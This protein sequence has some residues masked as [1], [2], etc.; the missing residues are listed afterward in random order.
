MHFNWKKMTNLLKT[1]VFGAF[2]LVDIASLHAAGAAQS[3]LLQATIELEKPVASAKDTEA[4]KII[5]GTSI[6]LKA[7]VVNNGKV[8][9]APG[10]VF[11][12]FALPPPLD[13][14]KNSVMFQTE[15][16]TLPSIPPGQTET[17]TFTSGHTWPTLYDFIRDD[18]SLRQYQAVV[19]IKDKEAVIGTLAIT[20]SAYYYEGPNRQ[21]PTE[22]PAQ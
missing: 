2:F 14:Q 10:T 17:L 1:T 4:D 20:F 15:K 21:L 13:I 19:N 18:W 6:K 22:V 7:K 8:A 3:A 12:R 11:I 9:S 16:V 5:P